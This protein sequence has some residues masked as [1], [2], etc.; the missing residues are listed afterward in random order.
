[1]IP[2]AAGFG[3]GAVAR[4]AVIAGVCLAV[5]LAWQ[6]YEGLLQGR[7][8]DAVAISDLEYERNQQA[9]L[10]ELKQQELDKSNRAAKALSMRFAALESNY[11]QREAETQRLEKENAGYKA[12]R[13]AIVNGVANNRMRERAN[14]TRYRL[15]GVQSTE[16]SDTN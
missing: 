4:I 6:H 2:F 9:A 10:V 3:W 12:W 11:E 5:W 16:P 7:I 8:D 15:S 1:M 13:D 14:Q